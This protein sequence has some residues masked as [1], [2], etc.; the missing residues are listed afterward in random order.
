MHFYFPI[1]RANQFSENEIY[2]HM[3][4]RQPC[5]SPHIYVDIL[6]ILNLMKITY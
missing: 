1:R 3:E 4:R 2:N 6:S 5:N